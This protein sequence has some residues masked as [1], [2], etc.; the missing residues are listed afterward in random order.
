ML[1]AFSSSSEPGG[2]ALVWIVDADGGPPKDPYHTAPGQ[3]YTGPTSRQP[4]GYR[5][6]ADATTRNMFEMAGSSEPF[7]VSIFDPRAGDYGGAVNCPEKNPGQIQSGPPES[8]A[9]NAQ[10]K[11][12]T[13]ISAECRAIVARL[14]EQQFWEGPDK[15]QVAYNSE[16]RFVAEHAGP[17]APG[18]WIRSIQTSASAIRSELEERRRAKAKPKE[19]TALVVLRG[20]AK[21]TAAGASALVIWRALN[22]Y[23]AIPRSVRPATWLKK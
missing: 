5:P 8:G 11:E 17:D 20:A 14:W 10:T 21:V 1:F 9:Y 2:A 23:P 19:S 6:A 13:P 18:M 12:I 3:W 15:V 16:A 22:G 7:E 4:M